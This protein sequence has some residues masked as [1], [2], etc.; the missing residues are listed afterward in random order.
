MT[1][2]I[3]QISKMTGVSTDS[4]RF[5]EK[6][7]I[8]KPH[9]KDNGYRPYDEYDYKALQYIVVMKYAHFSF[10]ILV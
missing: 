4:L 10:T 7:G 5:Y 2:T 8:L 1:W 9:R 3:R 6:L